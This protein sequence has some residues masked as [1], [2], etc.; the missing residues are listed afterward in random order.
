[1]YNVSFLKSDPRN[2]CMINSEYLRIFA[3]QKVSWPQ[4][5]YYRLIKSGKFSHGDPN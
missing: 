1:M 3:N 4:R 5:T 2:K